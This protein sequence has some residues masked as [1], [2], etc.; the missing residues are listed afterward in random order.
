MN[1]YIHHKYNNATAQ[2]FLPA[3]LELHDEK[4]RPES[5]LDCDEDQ[6]NPQE[7]EGKGISGQTDS[8]QGGD[9]GGVAAASGQAETVEGAVVAAGGQVH[10]AES[11]GAK[12]I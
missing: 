11:S 4:P 10:G 7:D 1:K 3:H 5:L 8:L 9:S 12:N 2:F 6:D